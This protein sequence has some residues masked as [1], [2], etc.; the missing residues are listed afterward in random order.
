[1]REEL[2]LVTVTEN[3]V[4]P[5]LGGRDEQP[6]SRQGLIEH[7]RL[8][9]RAALA[10][11]EEDISEAHW[12]PGTGAESGPTSACRCK[13]GQAVPRTRPGF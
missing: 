13:M 1:M 6:G 11:P 7:M 5:S 9:L 12:K 2:A 3:E 8:E 10:V 4:R